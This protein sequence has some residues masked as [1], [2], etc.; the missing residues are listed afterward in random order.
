MNKWHKL[1]ILG[2]LA[3]FLVLFLVLFFTGFLG[4]AIFFWGE[5]PE[6]I[7]HLS[8]V[9]RDVFIDS[10]GFSVTELEVSEGSAL[11]LS[12]V[13]KDGKIH[14]ILLLGKNK[15][16]E[17]EKTGREDFIEPDSSVII[18]ILAY[19]GDKEPDYPR[20]YAEMLLSCTTCT[21]GNSSL[22]IVKVGA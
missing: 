13:N 9:S 5:E 19:P 6:E 1:G 21:G 14:R 16:G 11:I 3:F 2:F 12:V 22:D 17:F 7:I 4:N 8:P 15:N 20:D 18:G 10:S